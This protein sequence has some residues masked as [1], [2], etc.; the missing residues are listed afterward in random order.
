MDI[1]RSP[2]IQ[3]F[4]SEGTRNASSVA[5]A[6][7]WV[8]SPFLWG[9]LAGLFLLLAVL[10]GLVVLV[11]SGR[12]RISLSIFPGC[13]TAVEVDPVA[14]GGPEEVGLAPLSI[15]EGPVARQTYI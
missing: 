6:P 9:S 12:L 8:G 13:F 5:E 11:R 2:A 1:K 4:G 14:R 7:G 10:L 15:R 3:W